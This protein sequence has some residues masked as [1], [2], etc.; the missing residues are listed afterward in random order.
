MN[1]TGRP[2]SNFKVTLIN[3]SKL[4]FE[5]EDA[6]PKHF[7]LSTNVEVIIK[8]H[9]EEKR[10]FLLQYRL[11]NYE[12]PN[13]P[14]K[15]DVIARC[16][17]EYVGDKEENISKEVGDFVKCN[18]IYQVSSS[19]NQMVSILASQVGIKDIALPQPNGSIFEENKK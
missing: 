12:L 10:K 5:R 18:A 1:M 6:L 7:N 14:V 9:N 13:N 15:L 2:S 4:F 17:F 3:Y 11:N 16:F 8:N 19:C